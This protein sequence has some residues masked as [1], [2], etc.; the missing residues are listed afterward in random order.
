[1]YKNNGNKLIN[2][3]KI[4]RIFFSWIPEKQI[5]YLYNKPTSQ[6]MEI[7]KYLEEATIKNISVCLG[8]FYSPL[9]QNVRQTAPYPVCISLASRSKF[10]SSVPPFLKI[11]FY[12]H[13]SEI[14]GLVVFVLFLIIIIYQPDKDLRDC[15]LLTPVQRKSLVNLY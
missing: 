3:Q 7:R 2:Q 10:F 14:M 11:F 12:P 1:M 9:E 15:W 6:L 4:I 13:R 5:K 8:G